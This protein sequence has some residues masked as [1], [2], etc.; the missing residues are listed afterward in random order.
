[1]FLAGID[2]IMRPYFATEIRE[3]ERPTS[4]KTS[5]RG[6]QRTVL[7]TSRC[8]SSLVIDTLH[9]RA[10]EKNVAVAC[11]YFDLL[12]QKEQS[13]KNVLGALLK[14][15]V[16]GL[17]DIPEEV[18]KVYHYRKN[19][20]GGRGPRFPE[21]VKMLQVVSSSQ[22]TFLCVDALDECMGRCQPDVLNSLQMVLQGSPG[23][24]LFLTGRA[25]IKGVVNGYF[26]KRVTVACISP[27]GGDIIQYLRARL[28]ED[29][30][31]NAMDRSLEAE[32]LKIIPTAISGM[33]VA[34]TK[35]WP[36]PGYPLTD[37]HPVFP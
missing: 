17:G 16:S 1:M 36:C 35:L 4:R 23:T 18:L 19:L 2:L 9:G 31:P 5:L 15:M 10:S 29:T 25:H 32:I 28:G 37:I 6:K 14:Q 11:F 7:L 30:T 24:R 22:C 34:A 33:Y 13:P 12:A 26:H 8:V 27:S 3:W 20:I 21:L